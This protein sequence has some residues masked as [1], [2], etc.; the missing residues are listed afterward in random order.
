MT[1]YRT[2]D[3]DMVD[4]ICFDHYGSDAMTAAVY[5]AN[6]GLASYGPLLPRGILITL[7]DKPVEPA[8]QPKRLWG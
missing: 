5:A 7:P 4:A 3:G 1:D 6:P 8:V 2:S